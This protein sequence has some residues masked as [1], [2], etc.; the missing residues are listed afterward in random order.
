MPAHALLTLA[1][2]LQPVRETRERQKALWK[3]YILEYC[4][5]KRVR[6]GMLR[7]VFAVHISRAGLVAGRGGG[8]PAV[9]QCGAEACVAAALPRT[10]LTR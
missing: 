5:A 7:R 6:N 9:L 8:Q 1:R 3:D 10:A 4:R 2:R